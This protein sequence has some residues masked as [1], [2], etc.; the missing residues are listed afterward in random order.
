MGDGV[1]SGGKAWAISPIIVRA[2]PAL[3]RITWSTA[4]TSTS[5]DRSRQQS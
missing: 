3:A 2:V 5:A 4:G 1:R